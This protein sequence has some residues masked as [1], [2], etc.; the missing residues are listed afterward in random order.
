MSAGFGGDPNQGRIGKD[1]KIE[2]NLDNIDVVL[3]K[4]KKIKK[5]MKSS[6]YAVKTM[7][8]TEDIV[9]SLIKEAEE[10]PL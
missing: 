6:L 9:S 5:Y 3:K 2:I 4:Y 10:N 8:G 1:A 7:D